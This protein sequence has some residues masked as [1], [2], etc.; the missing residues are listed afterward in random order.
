MRP[1]PYEASS[2]ICSIVSTPSAIVE[3]LS[4]R[5]I[6][7]MVDVIVASAG[8][9]ATSLG[10]SPI[11]VGVIL[12]AIVGNAAEH[13][14]AVQLAL[15]DDMETATTITYQSSLQVALFVTPVLVFVSWLMVALGVGSATYLDMVFTPL[16]VVAV[17]LAVFTVVVLGMDGRTNW[18]EGALLLGL[19]LILGIAF[20]F[21]PAMPLPVPAH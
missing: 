6:C 18:F 20:F 13:S 11:F 4:A 17:I 5:A 15:V 1:Q 10:W 7:T 12:L 3:R 9:V 21:V 16:E 2:C 14:T 8:S 19:Y